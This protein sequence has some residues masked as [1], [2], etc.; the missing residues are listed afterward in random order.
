MTKQAT[1][2]LVEEANPPIDPVKKLR[3]LLGRLHGK[4]YGNPK[5]VAAKDRRHKE[6]YVWSRIPFNESTRI[7]FHWHNEDGA[8]AVA[9]LIP[10]K[11]V[12]CSSRADDRDEIDLDRIYR[13]FREK[14]MTIEESRQDWA[15][16]MGLNNRLA[17]AQADFDHKLAALSQK[18]RQLY[19]SASETDPM[20]GDV[21]AAI[22][23]P[24]QAG[25]GH[26]KGCLSHLVKL[27]LLRKIQGKG[28]GYI[29]VRRPDN[30]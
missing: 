3:D 18:E 11:T 7:E 26:I 28:G 13:H 21:V 24:V 9:K 14:E 17:A 23:F 12:S 29:R 6:K 25:D 5:W 15:Y 22:K 8:K 20:R 2:S 16:R 10:S 1:R 4:T 30:L 27:G 19:E